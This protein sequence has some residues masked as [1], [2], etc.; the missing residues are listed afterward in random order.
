M[1]RQQTIK[2]GRHVLLHSISFHGSDMRA[3]M[4][5]DMSPLAVTA[6]LSATAAQE[7]ESD[8]VIGLPLL[9]LLVHLL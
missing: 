7:K 1:G 3:C 8:E 9:L 5:Q 4:L 6:N 2:L